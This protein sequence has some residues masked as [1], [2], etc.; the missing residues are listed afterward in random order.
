MGVEF[1]I[2]DGPKDLMNLLVSIWNANHIMWDDAVEQR[3]I[4]R[5]T[6]RMAHL[7]TTVSHQRPT[8]APSESW[9]VLTSS[10]LTPRRPL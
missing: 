1:A 9:H 3:V 7:R 5:V 10:V 2:R 8:R 4:H 6:L